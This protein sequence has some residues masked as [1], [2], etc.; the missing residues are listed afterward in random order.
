MNNKWD[1][2]IEQVFQS[3]DDPQHS[4]WWKVAWEALLDKASGPAIRPRS[5]DAEKALWMVSLRNVQSVYEAVYYEYEYDP[6]LTDYWASTGLTWNALVNQLRK[7][8]SLRDDG[9]ALDEDNHQHWS[10]VRD[11][12]HKACWARRQ[13][14]FDG[15]MAHLGE[16][17]DLA[18]L[19]LGNSIPRD[20]EAAAR[21][22]SWVGDEL[23]Y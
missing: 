13:Q 2:I 19:M 7:E 11:G 3:A 12:H 16:E 17:G 18:F 22:Y 8:G 23:Q 14:I 10:L 4:Q 1:L 20:R 9:I 6:L 5:S 15:L 21:M